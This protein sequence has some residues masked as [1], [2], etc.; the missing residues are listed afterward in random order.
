[1]GGAREHLCRGNRSDHDSTAPRF[2]A[3]SNKE[4]IVTLGK[5]LARVYEEELADTPRAEETYRY[6]VSVDDRD[7]D[8]LAAL[9]RIYSENGAGHA[10]AETLRKRVAATSDAGDKIELMQRLGNVLYN[11]VGNTNEAIDVFRA[12]LEQEPEREDTLRALQNVYLITQSW[13]RLFEVYEKELDVVVGDSAQAEILG[14][15]AMLAWTKLN[16]LDRAVKLL[17]RVLDLLGEDAEA[18]NALGNI[19]AMQENW[20]DL[21]DVLER[22]VGVCDEDSQRVKIYSDLGRIWYD[23]LHRD[24]NALESWER[25]L[26]LDPGYTDALFA[27]SRSIAPRATTPT[28]STRCTA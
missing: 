13:E 28:W 20:A 7:E 2:A 8:V 10:L 3:Q 25:V 12:I 4:A 11:D 23:K 26:D 14:R 9:D 17:R 21:V 15:M 27:I 16:D 19:Y 1:M 6:V 18:L 5:R 24:R 22:E